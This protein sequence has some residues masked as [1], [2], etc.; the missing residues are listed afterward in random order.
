MH[1]V[2]G[3]RSALVMGSRL[4]SRRHSFNAWAVLAF[5]TRVLSYAKLSTCAKFAVLILEISLGFRTHHIL[6]DS[7]SYTVFMAQDATLEALQIP[8]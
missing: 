3:V 1:L 8:F 7:R 6:I 5:I 2:G 4:F